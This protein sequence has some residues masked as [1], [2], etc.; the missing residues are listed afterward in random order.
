MSAR[1]WR[2]GEMDD[3]GK[4]VNAQKSKMLEKISDLP[5]IEG[6]SILYFNRWRKRKQRYSVDVVR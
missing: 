1:F 3:L 6:K 4:R 5:L 2:S